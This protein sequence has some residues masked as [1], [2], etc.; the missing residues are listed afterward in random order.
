MCDVFRNCKFGFNCDSCIAW[1]PIFLYLSISTLYPSFLWAS[2][3]IAF[4]K[5]NKPSSQISPLSSNGLEIN[6]AP[7]RALIEDLQYVISQTN[8]TDMYNFKE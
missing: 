5:W 8:V 2:E 4:S 3:V 1:P 6:N 7:K